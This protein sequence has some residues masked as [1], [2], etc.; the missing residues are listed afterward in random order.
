[1]DSDGGGGA[2]ED[3]E[4]DEVG[5]RLA[6]IVFRRSGLSITAV[7][8]RSPYIGKGHNG[9][10]DVREEVVAWRSSS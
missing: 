2:G 1:M 9:G 3:D 10:A 4:V 5:I 8:S 7:W 6:K